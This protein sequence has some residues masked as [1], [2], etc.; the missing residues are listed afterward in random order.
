MS[1][2]NLLNKGI[3]FGT[4]HGN[5]SVVRIGKVEKSILSMAEYKNLRLL[6]EIIG[7]PIILAWTL[8]NYCNR[9]KKDLRI[10]YNIINRI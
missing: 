3:L 10:Y 8:T 6:I 5:R 7:C 9:H 1:K 4:Y 2:L